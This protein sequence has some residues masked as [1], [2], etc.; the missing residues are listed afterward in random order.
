MKVPNLASKV[1]ALAARRL[2]QDWQK[3]YGYRP[4]LLETYAWTFALFGAVVFPRAL[5]DGLSLCG[6]GEGVDEGIDY[7]RGVW[8]RG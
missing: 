5:D 1:L 7:F 3:T 6:T 4:V 2:P 8:L